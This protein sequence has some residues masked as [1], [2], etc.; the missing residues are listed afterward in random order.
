MANPRVPNPASRL[1]WLAPVLILGAVLTAFEP[2]LEGGFVN[3]DD[4]KLIEQNA[5]FR[6]FSPEHLRWMFTTN[7]GGHWQPLTWL[8]YAVDDALHRAGLWSLEAFGFHL[9][10]VLLHTVSAV[11]VY[12]IARRLIRAASSGPSRDL[13][14]LP[15]VAG[16][17]VAALLFA[18]H[19]LRA[20]SVAWVTERRDVLCMALLLG[21]T[22]CWLRG[23]AGGDAGAPVS[24]ADGHASAL[25]CERARRDAGPEAI[26][27][28]WRLAALG[29]F[30][31]ALM[32]KAS[33]MV[34]PAALLVMDAYPL[35]RWRDAQGRP[36]L[37]RLLLEKTPMWLAAA[38]AAG[39]AWAA[40]RGAG[41]AYTL[42]EYPL[43][44]R[45]AQAC[46]GLAFYVYKTVVPV[47]LGPLI[48]IPSHD[49]L[50]GWTLW[51]TATLVA[52]VGVAAWR[53]RRRHPWAAAGLAV[54]VLSLA[55]VLGFFQSGPQLVA[56]RYSYLACLPLALI[57]GGGAARALGTGAG[58]P[59]TARAGATL[60]VGA[61]VL[62]GLHALTV[63]QTEHWLD[64]LSLWRQA[65]RACPTSSIAHVQYANELAHH[66]LGLRDVEAMHIALDHYRYA[67]SRNPKDV[68]AWHYLG[69]GLLLSEPDLKGLNEAR[70]ALHRAIALDP[71][72]A[73]AFGDLADVY[74]K[75][76]LY[77]DGDAVAGARRALDVLRE[78][79]E[80]N[81]QSVPLLS[82]LATMLTRNP[83]PSLRNAEE[84][85]RWAR[86][87]SALLSDENPEALLTLAEACAEA[88][89]LEEAV[90]AARRAGELAERR[91][92]LRLAAEA[93]RRMELYTAGKTDHASP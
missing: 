60:L 52:L 58:V 63:R 87:A 92:R 42:A 24:S 53:G 68:V 82:Q 4:D 26:S 36:R 50:L 14:S 21:S 71:R 30:V 81:P 28:P 12:F 75:L 78:G 46:R 10:N 70:D 35:R 65:I 45:L 57:A 77:E 16:A 89:R 11:L 83:D 29:L 1:R 20:E 43:T 56:D 84:A 40:Q 25:V 79:V 66:A 18:V 64:S 8:S 74:R 39:V 55:P 76:A 85:V 23:V 13:R 72:R 69:R 91:S 54:Y 17:A 7:A 3:W 38:A 15:L 59:L 62:A 9:T 27:L 93:A 41:A 49:E 47:G 33:A 73:E 5:S 86:Q 2:A 80:A 37:R 19:P 34:L 90:A 31:L 51:P 32:A 61:A 88:G 48:Q 67:L 44:L 6:G 22:L